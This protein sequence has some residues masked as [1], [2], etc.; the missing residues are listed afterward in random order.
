[1]KQDSNNKNGTPQIHVPWYGYVAF[2]M[3]ILMFSGSSSADGPLKVLG[4]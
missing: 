2:L 4:L 1:M 3:A